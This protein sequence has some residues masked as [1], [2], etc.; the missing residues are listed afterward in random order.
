LNT[1]GTD[2]NVL[3]TFSPAIDGGGQFRGLNLS[4]NILY[5]TALHG[6]PADNGTIFS[7]SLLPQLTIVQSG[8]N[9]ILSWPATASGFTLQSATNLVRMGIWNTVLPGPVDLNGQNTVSN[10]IS[11]A[12]QYYRLVQ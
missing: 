10:P 11:G 8:T 7:L 12:Q 1:E 6:G 9:A 2:F 4:G 5:G 3:H